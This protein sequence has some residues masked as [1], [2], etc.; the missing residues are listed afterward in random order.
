MPLAVSSLGGPNVVPGPG[1]KLGKGKNGKP[2]MVKVQTP[3]NVAKTVCTRFAQV[4]TGAESVLTEILDS[5]RSGQGTWAWAATHGP[6][7]TTGLE[8]ALKTL[9]SSRSEFHIEYMTHGL[10]ELKDRYE[11][12][13]LQVCLKSFD[14]LDKSINAVTREKTKLLG[15]LRTELEYSASEVHP[16]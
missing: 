3:T 2:P 10:K 15:H 1:K 12:E 11:D 5:V 8:K 6:A 4:K 7:F 16:A 13:E 14:N 9:N